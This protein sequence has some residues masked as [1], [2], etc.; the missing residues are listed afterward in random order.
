MSTSITPEE[1][2]R[3]SI[4]TGELFSPTDAYLA[5]TD[6]ER[7]SANP[8]DDH[9]MFVRIRGWNDIRLI[10]SAWPVRS[11]VRSSVDSALVLSVGARGSVRAARAT[12]GGS[13]ERSIYE[14]LPTLKRSRTVINDVF[15]VFGSI[16][17]I[18]TRRSFYR[19][20]DVSAWEQMDQGCYDAKAFEAEF[21]G[22]VGFERKSIYAVGTIGE[23]WRFD[24]A[25]R[26]EESG[27]N[28]DLNAVCV[29]NRGVMF[30]VGANG[31]CLRGGGGVWDAAASNDAGYT[32]W[33]IASYNDDIYATAN[34][35]LVL[36]LDAN[37]EFV[38]V[39]FGDCQIP[40]SAYHLKVRDGYLYSIG[41]K[42]IRRFD[43]RVW[44]DLL[45]LS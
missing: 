29:D 4:T 12:T 20:L 16:C 7:L 27:T 14:V 21:T 34:T 25:W 30:V 17:A 39:D 33:S 42:D 43:G 35:R 28:Q 9:S 23:I 37:G 38:P 22:V 10:E 6:D 1:L 5:V 32:F 13:D 18:G 40:T 41:S 3:F 31:T 2:G 19:R 36:R 45:T 44:E 8:D 24:G 15:D 11:Q 26:R